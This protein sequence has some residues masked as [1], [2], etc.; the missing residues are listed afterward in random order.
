[1]NNPN[2]FVPQGSML[3][4]I[5]KSRSRLLLAVLATFS[6][7]AVTLTLLLMQGC[8][9]P[10]EAVIPPPLPPDTNTIVAPS[11]EP[12]NP[13]PTTPTPSNAATGIA[14]S[15]V[16]VAPAPEPVVPSNPPPVEVAGNTREHKVE[17]GDSFYTLAKKY[18]VTM[19]AIE[20][21]NPGV[22]SRKLKLGQKLVIPASAAPAPTAAVSPAPGAAPET[23][24]TIYTVKSGDNLMKIARHAGVSL[25]ALRAANNLKTDR[26]T[27][28]QKLKIP[29]KPAPAAPAAE[30]APGS[31]PAPV[32]PAP[33]TP[34]PMP[35]TP[36]TGTGPAPAPGR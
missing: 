12:T 23:A 15:P 29:A 31:T 8:K 35:M 16:Y 4:R 30:P 9:K 20:A 1:M 14:P 17:K 24:E 11:F 19:K 33:M 22:D 27:V 36:A 26:I 7:G 25:K 34:A 5:N 28:G 2:P 6:V 32:T 3:E 10:D 21:A 18:G 13:P